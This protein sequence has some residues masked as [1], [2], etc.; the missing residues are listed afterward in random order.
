MKELIDFVMHKF[1][2][3]QRDGNALPVLLRP[4][5][6]SQTASNLRYSSQEDRVVSQRESHLVM[7]ILTHRPPYVAACG[8]MMS[9][10]DCERVGSLIRLNLY[11]WRF[12]A[13][14][15]AGTHVSSVSL[16][17]DDVRCH[18]P[19]LFVALFDR[20]GRCS[21]SLTWSAHQGFLLDCTVWLTSR[22]SYRAGL[23]PR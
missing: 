10:D 12:V 1:L 19:V 14:C 7:A 13:V 11:D 17:L 22:L 6:L 9:P 2:S 16:T 23:P 15:P 8:V 21:F 5:S 18:G 3:S 4:M 20:L